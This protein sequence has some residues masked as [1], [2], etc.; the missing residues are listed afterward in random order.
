MAKELERI[1]PEHQKE[2]MFRA[3]LAAKNSNL[4]SR[5]FSFQVQKCANLKKVRYMFLSACGI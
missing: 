2:L 3:K 4:E 5:G 1:S